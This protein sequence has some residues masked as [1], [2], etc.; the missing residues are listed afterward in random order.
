VEEGKLT[1]RAAKDLLPQI[2]D[3]ELPM[4]AAERLNLLSLDDAE[5]VTKAAMEAIEANPAVVQDY[6]GGKKAAVGRLIGETMQR[7]GGRAKPDAVRA[8]LLELLSEME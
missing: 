5:V 8:A 2:E 3:G 7:T 4:Q 1:A 6:L